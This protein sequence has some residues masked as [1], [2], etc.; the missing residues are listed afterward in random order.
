M[1][2]NL[3][4]EV[5][6]ALG[7][8]KNNTWM[9]ISAD[10]TTN[11]F[12]GQFAAQDV[13]E[14]VGQQQQET[15][16]VGQ[17]QPLIQ[18]S[19]GEA[20]TI[21]FRARIFKASA[22][23]GAW[24][25]A[26]SNPVSTAFNAFGGQEKGESGS[27]KE[28]IEK[29]KKFARKNDELGRPE[30]FTLTIGTE[31][32][33][34]V[35]LKSPGGITYDDLRADGTL[36]GAS[37]NMT[38]IKTAIEKKSDSSGISTASI[39]K[40]VAGVVTAVAGGISAIKSSRRDKLVNIPHGS[41]HTIDRF[42]TA[43]DGDTFEKIAAR[44]YGN[45]QLGVVLLRAQPTKMDFEAGDPLFTIKKD[46]IVQMNIEPSAPALKNNIEGKTLLDTYLQL[47]GQST[48]AI[49]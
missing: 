20:E 14:N 41:L 11:K 10:G 26:L 42:F 39:I 30:R 29:L 7:F 13:Q 36:K 33:F 40:T 38:F 1:A 22:L 4:G 48:S 17:Q 23:Q 16:G 27:V 47:R 49:I 46:E 6:V 8:T 45:A 21:T 2:L 12:V 34:T 9:L 35:L 31:L 19:S 28:Q 15:S 18:F 43:K 5:G 24:S 37:F 44:E 32:S 3:F 25:D